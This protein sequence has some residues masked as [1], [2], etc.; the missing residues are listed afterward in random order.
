MARMIIAVGAADP[1][2]DAVAV[3]QTGASD[4][5]L[6]LDRGLEDED[7][8]FRLALVGGKGA[9]SRARS[10][11]GCGRGGREVCQCGIYFRILFG[12]GGGDMVQSS[13]AGGRCRSECVKL[14]N[15]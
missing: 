9:G 10:S 14:A 13:V 4:L 5:P 2:A 12:G 15:Q 11:A 3:S 1:G 8:I 7:P 6:V